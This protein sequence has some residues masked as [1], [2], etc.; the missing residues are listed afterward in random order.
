MTQLTNLKKICTSSV[1]C[2]QLLVC[3]L[4]ASAPISA[5]AEA[6]WH[7]S[8]SVDHK[9]K[10]DKSKQRNF[11]L[12]NANIIG[13]ELSNLYNLYAGEEVSMS[14][15]TVLKGCFVNKSNP[16]SDEAMDMLGLNLA[17]LVALARKSSIVDS[18]LRSVNNEQ[19][20]QLCIEKNH[21]A[22][23]FLSEVAETDT[24]AP[25]F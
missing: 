24:I 7:C 11:N 16:L 3:S 8:R 2:A 9:Q 19:E 20:M 5:Q 14:G 4:W 13:I 15:G 6:I 25:C 22:V 12:G 21:P 18:H 17:T 1:I 23:G 10:K